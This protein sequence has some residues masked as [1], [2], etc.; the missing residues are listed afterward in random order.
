MEEE[1]EEKEW[2]CQVQSATLEQGPAIFSPF[3]YIQR[4]FSPFLYIHLL[5]L[6]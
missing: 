2:F 1:K 4:N 6:T 3:L 5:L